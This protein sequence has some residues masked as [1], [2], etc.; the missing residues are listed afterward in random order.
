[1]NGLITCPAARQST[2]KWDRAADTAGAP[3]EALAS[4]RVS[5]ILSNKT[6]S[7]RT[8]TLALN[9][10]RSKAEE[11]GLSSA[12]GMA[13][14][15]QPPGSLRAYLGPMSISGS[16]LSSLPFANRAWRKSP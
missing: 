13:I 2:A 3:G 16:D 9:V 7:E 10:T 15:S 11:D 14:S 6:Q 12:H 1:M 8:E 4:K 5:T